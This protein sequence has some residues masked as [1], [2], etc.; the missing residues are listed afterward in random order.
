MAGEGRENGR[1]RRKEKKETFSSDE[2]CELV[3]G[4][5]PIMDWVQ[6]LAEGDR[7]TLHSFYALVLS[8]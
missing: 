5:L 4:H 6:L 3:G 7:F 2:G 8:S 1:M